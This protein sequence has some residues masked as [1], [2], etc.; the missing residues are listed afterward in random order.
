M[1]SPI[2][3][4]AAAVLVA[5]EE[6]ARELT[7]QPVW[8][9]GTGQALDGFQLTSL[10]EDYAHWPALARAAQSA[11]GDGGR[12]APRRRRRRGPRLLRDRR[13]DRLRGAGFCAK[14]EAGAFVADGSQRLRRRRRREPARRTHGLRPSAR[15]HRRGA[16]GRGVRP[17]PRR[18]RRPPGPG[19]I[20]RSHA[21]QQR[22]GRARRDDLRQ[23]RRDQRLGAT[24]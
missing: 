12:R 16:G 23:E 10:H 15:R 7:D 17:A 11:Y 22:D 21:Q 2:T 3:D 20:G 18:G 19:R 6:R 1:C 24:A 14:G 4:G 13:D 8:I 9:R 5:S